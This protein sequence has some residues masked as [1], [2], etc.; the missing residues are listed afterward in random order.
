MKNLPRFDFSLGRSLRPATLRRV[1]TIGVCAAAMLPATVHAA[2]S[3]SAI[4]ASS[5][6]CTLAPTSSDGTSQDRLATM[7]SPAVMNMMFW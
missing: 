6:E 1:L 5:A 3:R 7:I 4:S 2:P